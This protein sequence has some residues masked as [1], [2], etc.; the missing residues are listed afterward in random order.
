MNMLPKLRN[1]SKIYF[2][3]ALYFFSRP[4]ICDAAFCASALAV[5]STMSLA[6]QGYSH[7]SLAAEKLFRLPRHRRSPQPP[8]ISRVSTLR[9]VSPFWVYSCYARQ[10][11]QIVSVHVYVH[12]SLPVPR[13]PSPTP[14]RHNS[15]SKISH[16]NW[17]GVK[18]SV[19]H[20]LHPQS[21]SSFQSN[22]VLR[23]Y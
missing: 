19:Y 16:R 7:F 13:H 21:R 11:S 12:S 17:T 20:L 15:T 4:F 5:C 22:L 14:S 8:N 3:S 2:S 10:R 9:E 23:L 18:Q 1:A 6:S